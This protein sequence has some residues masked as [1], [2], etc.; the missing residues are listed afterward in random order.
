[1]SRDRC[2]HAGLEKKGVHS[3][4]YYFGNKLRSKKESLYLDEISVLCRHLLDGSYIN[5][6][7]CL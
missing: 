6:M 3:K 7:K 5:K 1:M 2:T 4:G